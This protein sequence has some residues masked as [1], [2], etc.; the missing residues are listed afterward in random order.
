MHYFALST[1]QDKSAAV[2]A[3]LFEA[4]QS[5][6][7]NLWQRALWGL[8]HGVPRAERGRVAEFALK[9]FDARDATYVRDRCL[10]LVSRHAGPEQLRAVEAIT[11]NAMVPA[12][13]RRKAT[14]IAERLRR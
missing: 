13:L 11:Q 5:T 7:A 4:A 14:S 1:L 2:C 10:D 3:A 12:R 6:D 8:G 9:L